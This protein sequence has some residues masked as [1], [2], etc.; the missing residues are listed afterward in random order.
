MDG[1]V[2]LSKPIGTPL[3]AR[4]FESNYGLSVKSQNLSALSLSG[5]LFTM[6][7]HSEDLLHSPVVTKDQSVNKN[8]EKEFSNSNAMEIDTQN[9]EIMSGTSSTNIDNN[10]ND[11]PFSNPSNQDAGLNSYQFQYLLS[12][13]VLSKVELSFAQEGDALSCLL[14]HPRLRFKSFPQSLCSNFNTNY[15]KACKEGIISRGKYRKVVVDELKKS[16]SHEISHFVHLMVKDLQKY[17]NTNWMY[18][19]FSHNFCAQMD[20]LLEER[21]LIMADKSESFPT[22]N[23]QNDRESESNW[24]GPHSPIRSNLFAP[25]RNLRDTN[26]LKSEHLSME[27]IHSNNS[28]NINLNHALES[29]HTSYKDN[30]NDF[31][32]I[33]ALNKSEKIPMIPKPPEGKPPP[34]RFQRKTTSNQTLRRFSRYITDFIF[35]RRKQREENIEE[36]P[37]SDSYFSELAGEF[38]LYYSEQGKFTPLKNSQEFEEWLAVLFESARI[39]S[40]IGDT[41]QFLEIQFGEDKSN[42]KNI[43]ENSTLNQNLNDSQRLRPSSRHWIQA[44]FLTP[45]KSTFDSSNDN[46]KSRKRSKSFVTTSNSKINAPAQ[47]QTI[48]QNNSLPPFFQNNSFNKSQVP[49]LNSSTNAEMNGDSIKIQDG[50]SFSHKRQKSYGSLLDK[51]TSKKRPSFFSDDSQLSSVKNKPEDLNLSSIFP[52]N[53]SN[54]FGDD[55]NQTISK[56]I[57]YRFKDVFIFFPVSNS[58]TLFS[59]DSDLNNAYIQQPTQPNIRRVIHEKVEQLH[60]FLDCLQVVSKFHYDIQIS[61]PLEGELHENLKNVHPS[62]QRL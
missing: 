49:N 60:E 61:T 53:N 14:H 54:N 41:I 1:L 2:V 32:N 3:Y 7:V 4:A 62:L 21:N 44:N 42:T 15:A 11:Y 9:D 8:Q 52:P 24:I 19:C 38:Q 56:M 35:R 18:L 46:I 12:S 23:H 55:H 5:L 13:I 57:F 26:E 6:R 59:N 31:E 22:I 37:Q 34:K 39:L 27:A 58:S 40:S 17:W 50:T 45:L 25:N 51:F 43:Q 29:S 16:A 28:N 36:S 30:R 47:S 20:S 48:I 33:G 10:E